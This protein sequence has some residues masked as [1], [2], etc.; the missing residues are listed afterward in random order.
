M[1]HSESPDAKKHAMCVN[2]DDL[3]PHSSSFLALSSP[4]RKGNLSRV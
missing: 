1:I 4:E 3:T 2:K